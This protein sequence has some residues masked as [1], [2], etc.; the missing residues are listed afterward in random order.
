M[1]L[2]F[3]N[4]QYFLER[5]YEKRFW[6]L[7]GSAVSSLGNFFSNERT[8]A[9]NERI[10]ERNIQASKEAATTAFN[11]QR[12]LIQEQNE[13]NSYANQRKLMQEAGY[14]PNSLVS[15]SAGTAVSSGST[16]AP[17]AEIPSP[18]PMQAAKFQLAQ[19]FANI[20]SVLADAKL[21][22]AQTEKTNSETTGQ[23]L[24]NDWQVVANDIQ[25]DFGRL[26]AEYDLNESDSRRALN[27]SQRLVQN[28]QWSLNMDELYNMRPNEAAKLIS[29][30][31][32]DKSQ[33]LLNE[34]MAAKTDQE[35][36]LLLKNYV[37]QCRIAASTIA[38]NYAQA[39]NTRNNT[40]LWS[41]GGPLFK[42]AVNQN[43][44]S[45]YDAA[46]VKH[47]YNN[48]LGTY[49]A[50]LRDQLKAAGAQ[51]YQAYRM[52]TDNWKTN[53]GYNL[54]RSIPGNRVFEIPSMPSAPY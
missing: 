42:H 49:S 17:Q 54:L 29:S 40:A 32:V 27:D 31:L 24:Q 25:K 36:D 48:V 13:Y 1:N 37:L 14:N 20:K 3:L 2:H 23:Q 33:S 51:S 19:D 6:S 10:N 39:A 34:A 4:P 38:L 47:L 50:A 30:S 28:T 21:K 22:E 46:K 9:Q 16:N 15:G 18:I 7:L 53:I 44:M 43:T 5:R 11:R 45:A 52:I 8:N 12:Q 41:N 35:R 26:K